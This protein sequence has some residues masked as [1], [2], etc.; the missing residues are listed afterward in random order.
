[1]NK[2]QIIKKNIELYNRFEP[3][4]LDDDW[5]WYGWVNHFQC[6]NCGG[7]CSQGEFQFCESNPKE[8]ECWKCQHK[9]TLEEEAERKKEETNYE[10]QR[11]E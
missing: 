7:Y 9:E 1:M 6:T 8:V 5:R 10:E 3:N 4:I 2:K 11:S